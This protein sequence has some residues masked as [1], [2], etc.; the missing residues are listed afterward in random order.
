M[1]KLV[2]NEMNSLVKMA[3]IKGGFVVPRISKSL[4]IVFMVAVQLNLQPCY[5]EDDSIIWKVSGLNKPSSE[6]IVGPNGLLY[7]QSGNKLTM[8]DANGKKILELTGPG[9]SK[10]ARP[11]FGRNG[12]V[13][14]PGENKIQ[15]IKP[16]GNS[17][18]SFEVKEGNNKS[19]PVI[20]SGPSDL[21]YL[22]LPTALYAV[23]EQG[24]YK[25]KMLWD[26]TETNRPWVDT[27]REIIACTAD[28]NYLYVVYGK[29][30]NGYSMVAVNSEGE[31]KWRYRL[32]NIKNVG[33]ATSPDGS[34]YVSVNPTKIDRTNKGKVYL[35]KPGNTGKPEWS[36][37]VPFEELTAPTVSK[38]GELYFCASEYLYAV[39]TSDGKEIWRQKF[40]KAKTRP[41]VDETNRRIYLGTDDGRLLAVNS[42]KRLVWDVKLEGN[43]VGRPLLVSGSMLYVITDKGNLYKI[44]DEKPDSREGES[45]VI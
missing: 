29:K 8:V 3:I 20:S 14:L 2:N 18:W 7:V 9:G 38:Q 15:E 28:A 36:F 5:G 16:N 39:N 34:L 23:D 1:Q 13:F 17:G 35:F 41:M 37:S 45:N 11:V 42:H 19:T 4:I 43:V 12:S 24:Y 25:W 30:D 10:D 27:K 32:G 40:L 31:L 22:P 26:N 21:L 33:L 44:K 6:L